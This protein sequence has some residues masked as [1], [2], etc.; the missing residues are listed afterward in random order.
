MD[1]IFGVNSEQS[2]VAAWNIVSRTVLK[3]TFGK[4]VMIDDLSLPT[5]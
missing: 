2:V 3:T 4:N 5:A 1:F